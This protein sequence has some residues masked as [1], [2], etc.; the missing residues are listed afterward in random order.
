MPLPA[1]LREHLRIPVLAA[2][3]FI[4]SG[5]D[6][7]IEQCKAG[8]IG[9]FPALNARPQ[10][11][12]DRWLTRIEDAL[13]EYRHAHPERKVAPFA[14]NLI[15][16]KANKRLAADTEVVIAH[17]VPIVISSLSAPTDIVPRVHEYGGMV[18][19]DVVKLRHAE[20]AL[21]AGVDG[22]IAVCNGA[23]GHA[24]TL[25]PF[26][27]VNELRRIHT[28]PLV[29]S[30]AITNGDGV[31]AAEAMGCDLAYLGTRFIASK[32]SLA[33][34]R[35][36]QMIVDSSSGDIVYTPLFSG[37]HGSYLAGSIKN[38]GLDPDNLPASETPGTYRS[39]DE[40]AKTWKD[41]WGA[42]Q[43]VGN[44]DDVPSVAELVDRLESEYHAA[45]QRIG[46]TNGEVKK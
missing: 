5:P 9:S 32:E 22:I 17:K 18:L 28:G 24:G 12:L 6:L 38:A 8:V 44:I 40:R 30:G 13:G 21:E 43:G 10:E 25:N 31:L 4:V 42:G 16:N 2:P 15:V 33:V 41:I 45:R 19:H 1:Q 23:G 20:K 26:A 36:K 34:D 7:V 14:V 46:L 39:R 35:Y 27:L 3:M 11:E 37:V 29:L